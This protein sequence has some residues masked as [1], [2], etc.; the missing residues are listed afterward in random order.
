MK[1]ITKPFWVLPAL[2]ACG[3]CLSACDE[4]D[5]PK[6]AETTE[7]TESVAEITTADEPETEE[8]VAE[9]L[10][11]TRLPDGTYSVRMNSEV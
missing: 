4:A 5:P 3:L 1:N 11:F 7:A 2:L 6:P 8:L 9:V 10:Q